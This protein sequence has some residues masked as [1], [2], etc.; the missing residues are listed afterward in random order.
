MKSYGQ[1]WREIVSED[2]LRRAWYD[3]RRGHSRSAEVAAFEE[4]ID[5]NL[6]ALRA[7]L[8]SCE[9]HPAGYHQFKILDPKPRT[10]SCAP[11]RDRIVHHA[12]CNL[13]TPLLEKSFI[14]YTFACREGKGAHRACSLARRYCGEYRYFVK[15]DVR[16]YFDT[17]DHEKLLEV[18]GAKFREREVRDLIEKIVRCPLA[19]QE[20]GKGLP[21]GNL[22]SQW[23]ANAF[24]DEFDHLA[25]GGFGKGGVAY[26]RYMDDFVFFCDTKAR[27][28]ELHDF[29]K[30]WLLEHRRLEL[31]DEATI[32]APVSEGL[33][34]L[35]LR[36]W[37]N[38][39]RFRRERF[40]RTRRTFA[41]RTRQFE[42]GDISERRFAACAASSDGSLRWFGFKNILASGRG[43]S[44][45]SNR[46]QRGGNWNN[47]NNNCRS[48]NRN[49]NNPSNNNNN[50]GFRL[51]ST[52]SVLL[53]G[54]ARNAGAPRNAETNMQ[55]ADRQVASANAMSATFSV[56]E[57]I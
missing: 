17:I 11:V 23:F 4:D 10:I 37:S 1:L 52:P 2:N 26:I 30:R 19:G 35:G 34:F 31:K 7:D 28:W 32:I 36:I 46:V 44:S 49:N 38:G 27:A 24:L 12:L 22:T 45:G 39:W 5:A 25:Q 50:I 40:L 48:T 51:S 13:I 43:A 53:Q 42:R 29:S 8:M 18:I 56:G 47:D 20:A 14:H 16:H 54:P 33:P 6:E 55:S 21:I 3:V 57:M 41:N 15:L 9:Y